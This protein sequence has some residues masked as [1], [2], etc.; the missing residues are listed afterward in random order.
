M[1]IN[2]NNW[3]ETWFDTKYYHSLYKNRD[4]NEAE[5]FIKKV[6]DF[7]GLKNGDRVSDIAC[8]KGR[9]S[10]VLHSLGL[11]VWG[12]DLSVNSIHFA[13]QYAEVNLKFEVHDMREPFPESEFDAAFNL[14]TSFGY[15]DDSQE[16]KRC[17]LNV[18]QSLAQNGFFVQDYLNAHSVMNLLPVEEKKT[19][20]NVVFNIRKLIENNHIVKQIEV[21]DNLES[22]NFSE[23]VRIY[24][25]E[26]LISLHEEA[27]FEI[28]QT[29]GNYNLD[30]FNSLNSPRI[31]IVSKKM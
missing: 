31:V 10:R 7:L 13:Q 9:H 5:N 19:E 29:F 8:G 26:N 6:V 22:F 25:L 12:M 18:Y 11:S 2:S 23:K 3:F 4:T 15:F 17:I 1:E 21:L 24:S 14:F 27:G 30:E 16:D 28:V 20:D